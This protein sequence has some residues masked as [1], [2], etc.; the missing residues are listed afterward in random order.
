MSG[1]WCG[2]CGMPHDWRK[3]NRL[4]TLQVGDTAN[5]QI[6]FLAYNDRRAD[7]DDEPF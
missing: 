2:A 1:W 6:V 3:P 4:L 5:D 7:V